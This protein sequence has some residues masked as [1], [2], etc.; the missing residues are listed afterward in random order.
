MTAPTI[1]LRGDLTGTAFGAAPTWTDYSAYLETGPNGEPIDITWGKQDEDSAPQPTRFTF[2]LR[3]EDGRFTT[4]ASIIETKHQF[5]VQ[6]TVGGTTYDRGT[7]YVEDV[8]VVWPGGSSSFAVV[9]VTCVDISGRLTEALPLRA[10]VV[11]EML[12]DSPTYL[13]PL[14]EEAPSRSAADIV[15]AANPVAVRVD[16]KYGANQADFGTEMTGTLDGLTGVQFG[17]NSASATAPI[18]VLSIC[19]GSTSGPFVP[20]SGAFSLECWVITPTVAPPW[21]GGNIL[22]MSVGPSSAPPWLIFYLG[23]GGAIVCDFRT[24]FAGG[25]AIPTSPLTYLDGKLHHLVATLNADKRT[26]K[27]YIDGALVDTKV[28]TSDL[29]FAGLKYNLIGG[30]VGTSTGGTSTSFAQFAGAISHVAMYPSELSAARVLVHYQAGLGTGPSERSDQRYSRL[31]GYAGL[32]AS[33]LPTGQATMA[34]QRTKDKQLV[35]ALRQVADTEGTDSFVKPNGQPTFQAR[36]IRYWPTSAFTLDKADVGPDVVVRRDRLGLVNDQT[37]TRDGGAAQRVQNA[38]SIASYGRRDGGTLQ[39]ASSTDADALSNAA[40]RVQ[41]GK[42]PVTRLSS[43]SID[44]LTQP[45]TATVQAIMAATI[46]TAFALTGMPS[47]TPTALTSN[48][49]GLFVEGGH[50]QIAVDHWS[51]EFFTS[52]LAASGV[53]FA[54]GGST[55]NLPNTLRADGSPSQRTKLDAGLKIPF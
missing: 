14:D 51:I 16:G 44:L 7:G 22:Y 19:S 25:S 50:E 43:V 23:G 4:G 8:E 36:N 42:D 35:D 2:L 52:P 38:A 41:T 45:T 46:S 6:V 20:A 48:G 47:Q 9:K 27:L 34:G 40:W 21:G 13:Y 49:A 53:S 30:V 17:P 54:A 33:G 32:T 12:A 55:P 31:L 1:T 29:N 10:M 15:S 5:N 37:A 11:H 18:S 24:D 26:A 28:A 3:N 39:V